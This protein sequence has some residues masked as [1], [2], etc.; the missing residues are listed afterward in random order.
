MKTVLFNSSIYENIIKGLTGTEHEF[1]SDDVKMKLVVEACQAA[2]A[3][4][5]IDQLEE[6]RARDNSFGIRTLTFGRAIILSLAKGQVFF[7]EVKSNVLRLL[8]Q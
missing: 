2:N 3:S 1:A 5:F 4:E 6:V 8:E 7:Q